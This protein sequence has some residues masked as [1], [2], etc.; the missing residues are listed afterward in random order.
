MLNRRFG[1]I[2][3]VAVAVVHNIGSAADVKS[4]PQVGEK[5]LSVFHP[6]NCN[7]E[8]QGERYCLI[9]KN[10]SNPVAMIFARQINPE[11]TKLIKR[12]DQATGNNKERR[13]GSFVVFLGDSEKLEAEVKELA[14]REKVQQCILAIDNP[15]GPKDFD[16]G[17]DAEVTVVLYAK[18]TVKANHA[19][20]KGEL[21]DKAIDAILADLSRM[22][23]E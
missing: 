10:G 23:K 3:M 19:F 5:I 14:T 20:K 7:G 15:E 22:L 11:L 9:C 21:N 12:I 2:A 16:I 4:G 18:L 1:F 6:L 13:M 8:H 17:P